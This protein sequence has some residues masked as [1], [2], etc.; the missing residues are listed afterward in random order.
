MRYRKLQAK[1]RSQAQCRSCYRKFTPRGLSQHY[2]KS[3]D[4]RCRREPVKPQVLLPT[5]AVPPVAFSL[6]AA[7]HLED[8][9]GSPEPTDVVDA[10]PFDNLGRDNSGEIAQPDGDD[11]EF[12]GTCV[13]V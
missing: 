11:G 3:P 9:F 2:N 5:A 12:D 7:E 13:T 8:L 4:P 1:A 10:D 6:G